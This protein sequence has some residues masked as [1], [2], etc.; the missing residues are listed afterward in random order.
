[1]Q[2]FAQEGNK[3]VGNLLRPEFATGQLSLSLLVGDKEVRVNPGQITKVYTLFATRW[4]KLDLAAMY[5]NP[6]TA[7]P[8]EK[9]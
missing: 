5:N 3:P 4:E 1:L 2:I 6:D 8:L 7:Y 9:K